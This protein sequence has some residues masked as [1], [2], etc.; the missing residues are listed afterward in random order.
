MKKYCKEIQDLADRCAQEVGNTCFAAYWGI[1]GRFFDP[2]QTHEDPRHTLRSM[3]KVCGS[4]FR[5][6]VCVRA[7]F[8]SL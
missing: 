7:N 3:V 5:L 1:T 6:V 4:N 8:N 2:L